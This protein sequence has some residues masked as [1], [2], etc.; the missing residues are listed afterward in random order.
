MTNS[1]EGYDGRSA[2]NCRETGSEYNVTAHEF[3]RCE[4]VRTTPFLRKRQ[5]YDIVMQD[6]ERLD[7]F[8]KMYLFLATFVA[9]TLWFANDWAES[10]ELLDKV[11]DSYW[12][13]VL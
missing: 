5:E 3:V 12:L 9:Q 2:P 1:L 7:C 8:I 13:D 4:A 6:I 11:H 10:H